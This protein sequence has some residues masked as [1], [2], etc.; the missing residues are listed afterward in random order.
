MKFYRLPLLTSAGILSLSCAIP[1]YAQNTSAIVVTA[2]GTPPSTYAAGATKQLTQDTT[3]T[4]CTVAGGGGGGGGTVTQGAGNVANPWYVAQSGTWTTGR[5]WTLGSGTDSVAATQ[6][7]TWNL[8]NITGTITL[9][10]GA[11]TSALQTTG[12]STLTTISGQL[13]ASLGA[14]T[15]ATSLSVV[16]N[17]DTPF[18]VVGNVASGATDSGN[19]IKTSG[20]YLTTL[21]T[22]TS[23]QR[24]DMSIY[25]NGA[26]M[27]GVA[28]S[29][30]IPA[31]GQA[32]LNSFLSGTSTST[33]SA[34]PPVAVGG[35]AY[36]NG[37]MDKVRTLQAT[38]MAAGAGVNAV[39]IVPTS[40]ASQGLTTNSAAGVAT[41]LAKSSAGNLFSLNIVNNTTAGFAFAYDSASA[42]TTG[43]AFTASLLRYCFP[44]AASAGIDKTWPVPLA[45]T[46]GAFVGIST[47][48][49]TYTTPANLPITI[50]SQVK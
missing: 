40:N 28:S 31:D 47:S 9:P 32:Q 50:V 7:G 19:G 5:T 16:P 11:S 23:G 45:M 44:V 10:T 30:G 38:D 43:T 33:T 22:S 39:G 35:M 8:T 18:Q 36:G 34:G 27:V 4:L 37:V 12:N 6:S 15:G 46:N 48:C 26:L 2:C 20:V 1:A 3:G 13:P 24:V 25:R 29:G 41:L 17:T 14:K 49:T 42:L 21:P